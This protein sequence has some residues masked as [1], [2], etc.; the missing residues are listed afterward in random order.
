MATPKDVGQATPKKNPNEA[1][2]KGGSKSPADDGQ[3]TEQVRP[4]K[5]TAQKPKGED[6]KKGK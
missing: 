6:F 1:P 2:G 3:A 5:G 4:G